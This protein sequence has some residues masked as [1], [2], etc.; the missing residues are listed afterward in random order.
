VNVQNS[1]PKPNVHHVTQNLAPAYLV[2]SYHNTA[3]PYADLYT[4][5]CLYFIL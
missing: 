1:L 5:R 2:I 4:C 3:L